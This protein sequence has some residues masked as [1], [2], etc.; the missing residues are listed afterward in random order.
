MIQVKKKTIEQDIRIKIENYKIH[1]IFIIYSVT[2]NV[3][4]F[5]IL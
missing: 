4:Y 5:N 1:N 2:V 3:I